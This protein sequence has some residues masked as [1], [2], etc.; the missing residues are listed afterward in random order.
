LQG[1]GAG[2]APEV[3][4]KGEAQAGAEQAG[5][6]RLEEDVEKV[7]DDEEEDLE[8]VGGAGEE[9]GGGGEEEAEEEGPDREPGGGAQDEGGEAEDGED[10][11]GE[12]R[13]E[14]QE[15][16]GEGGEGAGEGLGLLL[17][18]QTG[19]L[20]CKML[21]RASGATWRE[22][23]REMSRRRR[24]GSRCIF[25]TGGGAVQC[26]EQRI[27]CCEVCSVLCSAFSVVQCAA[28]SVAHSL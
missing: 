2:D 14:E 15:Q 1:G 5:P 23:R 16:Q 26:S 6:R 28:L 9:G 8:W 12:G 24:D 13:Q 3:A 4:H 27:Q 21:P 11:A 20:V 7:D 19:R 22:R 10:E 17:A 18:R 25:S